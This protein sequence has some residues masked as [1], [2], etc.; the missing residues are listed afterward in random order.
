MIHH[1]SGLCLAGVLIV[2]LC[3]HLRFRW[4]ILQNCVSNQAFVL[5]VT[6]L[7]WFSSREVVEISTPPFWNL[8]EE[9]MCVVLQGTLLREAKI[10]LFSVFTRADRGTVVTRFLSL[11]DTSI[12]ELSVQFSCS[13]VSD[14]ATPWI[15]ARQASLSITIS[16]SSVRLRSIESVMPSSH[17][18]DRFRNNNENRIAFKSLSGS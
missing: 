13:V 9:L 15:T 14:S 18:S 7:Q 8:R 12:P 5:T 10:S 17:P 3:E 11:M 4:I 2:S 16:R 1:A 6:V